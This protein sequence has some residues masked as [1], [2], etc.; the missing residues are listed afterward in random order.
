VLVF[1]FVIVIKISAVSLGNQNI[2]LC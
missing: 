1:V 2:I